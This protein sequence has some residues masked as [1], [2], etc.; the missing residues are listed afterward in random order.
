MN[1]WCEHFAF[2]IKKME[3]KLPNESQ[4]GNNEDCHDDKLR[5]SFFSL[6]IKSTQKISEHR[7]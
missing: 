7:K 2:S 1:V 4:K 3:T 6:K 5:F